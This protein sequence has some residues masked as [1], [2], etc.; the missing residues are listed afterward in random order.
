MPTYIQS[1]LHD[2]ITVFGRF[3]RQAG[4]QI[5]TGEIMSA[6]EA[7]SKINLSN[8]EDFRHALKTCFITNHKMI[9]LFDQLFNLYWRNPDKIEKVSDILR[10]LNESRLSKAGLSSMKDQVKELYNK[11]LENFNEKE[12]DEEKQFD[13]FLYSP[14]EILRE[15]RFDAYTNE[16]Y[17]EAK[18]FISRWMWK[19]GERK[20]RRLQ[21]GRKSYRLDIR[22]TIRNN[23]FPAQ[24]FIALNWKD[25]KTKQRPLVVLIDISGSMDHYTR[26]LLHFIFTIHSINNHLEAFTF[27]TRLSRITHYLRQKDANDAL[28]YVNESVQDWSG[29]TKIGETLETFNRMWTRRVLNGSAVVLIISDGWDTGNIDLLSKEVDRLHRSCHRLIWLNPNLGYENFQPLSQGLLA[30]QPHVDDFLPIHN[31]NSLT[32]LLNYLSNLGKRNTFKALA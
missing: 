20:L 22:N 5:G 10:K 27:G 29:G 1:R 7:S 19:F 28:E 11:Q 3:L 14:Q 12:S 31:L 16:E 8:R 32:D 21:K 30:I 24:D 15:K 6:I 17:D 23:I 4:C 26:I 25:R 18:D 2:A 9:P 13:V